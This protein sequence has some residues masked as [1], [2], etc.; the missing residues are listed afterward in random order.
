M[1][2][3]RMNRKGIKGLKVWV[4]VLG[5]RTNLCEG[6][7]LTGA[8]EARG[9]SVSREPE[10]AEAAVLVTCFVTAEA[11][12]KCRQLVRRARRAVGERGLV[13]VCGCWAQAVD[14]GDARN[15]GADLLVGSRGKSRLP[16]AL[17]KMA[18][19]L[20]YD[21]A[22]P[23]RDL[24]TLPSVEGWEEMPLRNTGLHT[25]AFV[26][27]QDGCSHF[28]TYCII[29]FLR[30]RPV[31]RPLE[32]VLAEVRRLVGGGCREVVLTGIHL[33]TYGRDTGSSLAEL[34]RAL[35][36]IEGLERL[37][38]GSLEPF[39]LDEALLSALGESPVFC[40]HLHLPVQSGD[41]G[42][43]G[44]MRRGYTAEEFVCVCGAAR[45]RL[46]NDLHISSDILVGFP[47]EG[48]AAFQNTLSL[49]REVGLGRVHVFPF[50]PRPGTAAA[51]MPDRVAPEARDERVARALAMGHELLERYAGGFIGRELDVLA[52]EPEQEGWYHGHTPHF[53]EA[54]WDTGEVVK[55]NETVH[56]RV[57]S[58]DGGQ[59]EGVML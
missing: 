40:P 45:A 13:A 29:P 53:L 11:G 39:S 1:P 42:I 50:S 18:E 30:G 48:E 35:S 28:C 9:A 31:S 55:P 51:Q 4:H 17:E 38:L 24:R 41:D 10:G 43:L 8:L 57:L 6:D 49:M 37:R 52:E 5:C 2:D 22:R 32:S 7:F 54:R 36:G 27:V 47:G 26:K 12:R 14:A 59:L 25:R 21:G 33:G 46:G 3:P 19:G 23:F 34:V 20:P 56:I 16:D 58:A 15:L 44:L